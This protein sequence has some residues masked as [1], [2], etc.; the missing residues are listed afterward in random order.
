M[1]RFKAKVRST[2]RILSFVSELK[3]KP[4]FK[5]GS[6]ETRTWRRPEVNPG[7]PLRVDV[8]RVE[9]LAGGHEQPVAFRTTKA[10]IGGD[11]RQMD[12]ADQLGLRVPHRHSI[13]PDGT[14]GVARAPQI[15]VDVAARRPART[16]PINHEIGE[17]LLIG[18]LVGWP[19]IEDVYVAFAAAPG[20]ARARAGADHVELLVVGRKE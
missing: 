8:E 17:E 6:N 12:A 15:A 2:T 7:S 19:N 14:A 4:R 3:R 10:H 18:E 1:R 16:S 13:V 11:L 20:I 5:I 9:R